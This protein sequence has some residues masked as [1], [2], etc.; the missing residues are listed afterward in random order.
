SQRRFGRNVSDAHA[1]IHVAA[2]PVDNRHNQ[3]NAGTPQSNESPQAQNRHL[4]PLIRNLD[5]EQQINPD[6]NSDPERRG[7][8]PPRY[9]Q[10]P[11]QRPPRL[12]ENSPLSL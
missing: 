1:L 9:T 11:A 5:R 12:A 3:K 2:Q 6:R 8:P 4:L 10:R 7:P